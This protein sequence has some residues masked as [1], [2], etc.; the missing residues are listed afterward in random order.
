MLG[1]CQ[2]STPLFRVP[3]PQ[4]RAARVLLGLTP[5]ARGSLRPQAAYSVALGNTAQSLEH[6]RRVHA[7]LVL[8]GPTHQRWGFPDL[9]IA[10]CAY[11]G[12]TP[13]G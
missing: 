10:L 3:I 5:R 7:P 6:P 4:V 12:R 11:Q 2:G 1:A 13:R 9:W 8:L